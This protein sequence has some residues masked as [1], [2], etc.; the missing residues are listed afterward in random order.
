MLWCRCSATSLPT[1]QQSSRWPSWRYPRKPVPW[2]VQLLAPLEERGLH[3]PAPSPPTVTLS[4]RT[5][6]AETSNLPRTPCAV[7]INH[8]IL[9]LHPLGHPQYRVSSAGSSASPFPVASWILL[10][11]LRAGCSC[12]SQRLCHVQSLP[13]I[14]WCCML[15]VMLIWFQWGQFRCYHSLLPLSALSSDTGFVPDTL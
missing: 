12:I 14:F 13:H 11:D 2:S 1:A 8:L 3:R 6:H 5:L 15:L 7:G 10:P 4:Q 9:G